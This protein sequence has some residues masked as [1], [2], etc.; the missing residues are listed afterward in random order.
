MRILFVT[1]GTL[2]P[3]SR[4]RVQQ[5]LPHF[6]REG[7]ECQ[8]VAGYGDRYNKIAAT[9][10]AAPYKLA[11]R[12][13]RFLKTLVAPRPDILFLQ[14]PILPFSAIPE[15][16]LT[17]RDT[18]SIFDVDDAIFLAPDSSDS[19]RRRATFLHSVQRATHYFAG[20]RFLAEQGGAPEKT[21]VI[22]TVIDTE[23]Y[24]PGQSTFRR[25]GEVVIGWIGSATTTR[26]LDQVLPALRDIR[27]RYDH[28]R[29][30]IVSSHMPTHLAVE[31]RFEFVPWS[32]D[33]EIDALRSFDIGIM[34]M[35]HSRVSLGKCGFKMIQY[36]AMG[37]AVVADPF[38]ANADIFNGSNAG[39]LPENLD[40]WSTA[41]AQLV[42]DE[43]Y[44][45][46]CGENARQHAEAHYSIRAVLPQYLA[47][48]ERL[49][50]A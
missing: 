45:Q 15:H 34:P 10:W 40:Q 11:A 36:M 31:E 7:I 33:Q 35:E 12:S 22:P 4:F 41:L 43:A 30:R 39:A 46:R 17:L 23:R 8:V 16:L 1:E 44:R 27:N 47:H 28:V 21:S 26:Y 32:V 18:P 20:N 13:Q 14:R 50:G 37:T 24:A 38:G 25:Q 48:F 5:F 6:E 3:S 29:I 9:R 49:A 42:E 2:A 19:P